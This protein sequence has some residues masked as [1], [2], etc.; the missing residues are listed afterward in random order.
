MK[1]NVAGCIHM[2]ANK[3]FLTSK[4]GIYLA[5]ASATRQQAPTCNAVQSLAHPSIKE[6]AQATPGSQLY[7]VQRGS[8]TTYCVHAYLLSTFYGLRVNVYFAPEI[9]L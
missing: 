2:Y 7:A 4:K 1:S 3:I 6:C 9:Q 8:Y 5:T